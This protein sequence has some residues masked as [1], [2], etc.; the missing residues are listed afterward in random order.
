MSPIQQHPEPRAPTSTVHRPSILSSHPR[1]SM[2]RIDRIY[3]FTQK[4]SLV[5]HSKRCMDGR[6][7]SLRQKSCR[8]CSAA[9]TRCDLKRPACSRCELRQTVCRYPVSS[10]TT[11]PDRSRPGICLNAAR[12]QPVKEAGNGI[13]PGS[14][15]R[16]IDALCVPDPEYEP[17]FDHT[18]HGLGAHC[19]FPTPESGCIDIPIPLSDLG[20]LDTSLASNFG[21]FNELGAL[22]V[23]YALIRNMSDAG[24]NNSE[25]MPLAL[26]TQ[27]SVLKPPK[28]V[29]HSMELIL[30]VTRT[31]PRKM[32]RGTQLPPFIHSTQMLGDNIPTPLANC[33]T[34]VK[35]W[36]GQCRGGNSIVL[37][38]VKKETQNLLSTYQTFDEPNL[39]A[40]LQALTIYTILLLFPFKEQPSVTILDEK[41]FRQLR[42]V[43]DYA[44]ITGLVLEDESNNVRPSWECWVL[45]TCKRCVALSLFIIQWAYCIYHCIPSYSCIGL[46]E[47]PAPAAKYLWQSTRRDQWEMLYNR[48][49]AQWDGSDFYIEE[50][51][52]IQ[53]GVR[54]SP[55]AELWLEDADEYGMIFV[56]LRK[57]S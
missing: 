51:F 27:P 36:D 2:S 12:E 8:D 46:R 57:S 40:A 29:L 7:E 6:S 16:H 53:S 44:R 41:L 14:C 49:L 50:F 48:W 5:R 24:N 35:M 26:T 11:A 45:V 13:S 22:N 23:D 25:S 43:I 30:R 38:T 17:Q 32:A 4:S 55:R 21:S 18:G 15:S 31:W 10:N 54:M 28:L 56:S 42:G 33:F 19:V 1:K 34:L 3:R 37:Q 47:M 20:V 39:V 9:K 52:T